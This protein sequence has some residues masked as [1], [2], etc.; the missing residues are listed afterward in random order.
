MNKP[1]L[2]DARNILDEEDLAKKGFLYLGIGR[3]S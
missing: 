1:V 3:G 2:I